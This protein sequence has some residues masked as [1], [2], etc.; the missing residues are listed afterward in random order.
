[1]KDDFELRQRMVSEQIER[2]GVRSLRVLAAMRAVQRHC[3]V[4]PDQQP[5]AYEDRPLP[6][7]FGQTISQPYI[8]ALMSELAE[9][10]LQDTVLEIGTGSGY[11]AAV[12]ALLARQ[13]HSVERYPDLAERARCTLQEEKIGNVS[14]HVADGSLGWP[15]AAP[16]Q[17]ILVTAAAP[18]VP[19]P[20]QQQLAEGGRLIIPV[21]G[22]GG[23]ELQSWRKQEGCMILGRVLGVAFV[24]LRGQYGWAEGEFI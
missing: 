6:I 23:Q 14:V 9:L 17:A 4:L 16:Y 22:R 11:Q 3:F 8:V 13:V 7:G 5:Y 1:M 19:E 18:A 2:R 15:E 12:L 24:P 21:G 10:E 20:L